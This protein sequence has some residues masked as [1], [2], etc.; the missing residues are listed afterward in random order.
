MTAPILSGGLCNT[1]SL[2]GSAAR[3]PS[4]PVIRRT[5]HRS[6]YTLHD[7]AGGPAAGPGE[8][9]NPLPSPG[10]AQAARHDA[11]GGSGAPEAARVG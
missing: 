5:F 3:L 6:G 10:S 11:P 7:S 9:H 4:P 8:P 2:C 1:R